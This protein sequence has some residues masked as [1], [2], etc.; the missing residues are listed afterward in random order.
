MASHGL[1]DQ[2][3]L[4]SVSN[5]IIWRVKILSV[6]DEYNIKNHAENVPAK[7]ANPDPLK[8]FNENQARAKHLIMDGLKD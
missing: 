5:F 1:R 2:D 4:D 6:L 3:R 8:K 7:P